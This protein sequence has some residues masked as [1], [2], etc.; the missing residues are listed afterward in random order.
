VHAAFCRP[1]VLLVVLFHILVAGCGKK[2]PPLP[3]L[4]RVPAA[5][6]QLEVR[7]V[8]GSAFVTL[9]IPSQNV[10]ASSPADVGRVEMFAVTGLAPPPPA[11]FLEL[12]SRVATIRVAAPAGGD[13]A[14]EE[15][16][17]QPGTAITF[18]D[19]LAPSAPESPPV[20]ETHE[21]DAEQGTG[22]P[23]RRFYLAVA[24]STRGRQGPPSA[25]AEL[26]LTPLPEPPQHVTIEYG[27]DTL[28]VSWQPSAS[29]GSDDPSAQ[30][31]APTGDGPKVTGPQGP[32]RYNVYRSLE[33][34]DLPVRQ[35]DAAPVPINRAP[36][37][38]LV[39]TEPLQF[40]QR[41]RC[42]VVRAVHGSQP[43]L[44]EGEGSAPACV[45]PVDTFPPAAPRGL[46]AVAAAGAVSLIWEANEEPDLAGYLILRGIAGDATLTPL[47]EMPIRE[48][49]YT[50]RTVVPG[51][52][53]V[54]AVVALD[55][56]TPEPNVSAE[57]NRVEET[58]R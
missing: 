16:G 20:P 56:R 42:Y 48:T 26:P 27:P 2:G 14:P 21:R 17:P 23:L 44:V 49:R 4:V 8:G 52:R 15:G 37:E 12:A 50:D 38:G 31:P 22:E 47:M 55:D 11:R 30:S 36:I 39:F 46:S 13:A 5:P 54:Y 40:D 58:A 28:S 45:T 32:I 33:P 9:T 34:G 35:D 1:G 53:Y 57:S 29:V 51:V 18:R 19:V 25:V 41:E 3:P 7:R 10:D 43:H 6:E 24:Y